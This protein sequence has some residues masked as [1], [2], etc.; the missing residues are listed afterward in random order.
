MI[1]VCQVAKEAVNNNEVGRESSG[2]S[3]EGR[4]VTQYCKTK[5]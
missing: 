2:L 5:A 1:S 3:F 4:I